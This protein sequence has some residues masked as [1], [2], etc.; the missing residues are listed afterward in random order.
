MTAAS[1]VVVDTH[2]GYTWWRGGARHGGGAMFTAETAAAFAAGRNAEMKPEHALYRVFALVAAE[3]D[4]G[5]RSCSCGTAWA[6]EPGHDDDGGTGG[7]DTG[8]LTAPD[9]AQLSESAA[10]EDA[11]NAWQLDQ[12]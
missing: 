7:P 10:K 12:S 5:R 2:D 1:H 3:P 8:H 11:R 9:V 6:D 4:A